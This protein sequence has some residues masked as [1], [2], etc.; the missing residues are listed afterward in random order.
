[1]KNQRHIQKGVIVIGMDLNGM[2]GVQDIGRYQNVPIFALK[3]RIVIDL[4]LEPQIYMVD[5]VLVV[6]LPH[7]ITLVIVR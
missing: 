4:H 3:I 7:H 1:M 5:G 2:D 6:E